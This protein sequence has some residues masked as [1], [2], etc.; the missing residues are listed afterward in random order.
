ML[1]APATEASMSERGRERV[2]AAGPGGPRLSPGG[3]ASGP[4]ARRGERRD[5]GRRQG[6]W[7]RGGAREPQGRRAGSE[8][9]PVHPGS[10]PCPACGG[11]GSEWTAAPGDG[12][13]P[14]KTRRE[15]CCF[16]K[17]GVRAQGGGLCGAVAQLLHGLLQKNVARTHL[18][19]VKNLP[20]GEPGAR[21]SSEATCLE[22]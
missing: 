1:A 17:P 13:H 11:S 20:E 9:R 18:H 14:G 8:P 5:E 10:A 3:T 4:A 15:G 2:A 7:A 21:H 22:L 16:P 19:L 12:P 6:S